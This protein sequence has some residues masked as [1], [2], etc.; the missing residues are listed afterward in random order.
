LGF[1][2]KQV[3]SL[4]SSEIRK[5]F[6]AANA[7]MDVIHLEIGDPDFN[8]PE[9]ISRAAYEAALAGATHYTATTGTPEVRE[10]VAEKFRRDNGIP[11]DPATEVIVSVGAIGAVF[12]AVMAVTNPCDEIVVTDP[13]WP[14][15][16][17]HIMLPGG[18]LVPLP[19]RE[20]NGFRASLDDIKA[21]TTSRT[22]AL[23]INSPNNPTGSVLSKDELLEI[24]EFCAAHNIL[25]ISDEVYEKI[26][27]GKEHFSLGSVPE[28]KEFVVTVNSLSKTYAMTGWR[29]GFACG[30]RAVMANMVKVQEAATSCVSAVVQKAAV[31]ALRGPQEPVAEMVKAYARRR[32]FFVDGLNRIPGFSCIKP[33]GAFYAYPNVRAFGMPSFE[34][35]MALLNE[36][37]VATVHGSGLGQFGEGYVRMSFATSDENL[38]EALRRLDRFARARLG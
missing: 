16:V 1:E 4:P 34:L 24:G 10:A 20:E 22:K 7:M 13:N 33:D 23:I 6:N 31:A 32:E 35:A 21:V 26:I 14:N 3:A 5:I 30:P 18:R 27:Y 37:R 12:A 9:H 15:Y 19:L 2:S 8:T 11:C 25:V 17:S 29:L 38:R 28:F 36:V